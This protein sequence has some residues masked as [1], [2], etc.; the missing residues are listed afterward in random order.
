MAKKKTT[1]SNS[2]ADLFFKSAA[3]VGAKHGLEVKNF[4]DGENFTL[5]VPTGVY[6]L[7]E[8]LDYGKGLPLGVMC[9]FYG[10]ESA[11]KS[12]FAQK[13]CANAQTVY[14][15]QAI[16]YVDLECT[17]IRKRLEDIGLNLSKDR[18][19]YLD[20]NMDVVAMLDGLIDYLDGNGDKISMVVIDSIAAMY[21][22][23]NESSGPPQ[24]ELPKILGN[25]LKVL[26]GIAKKRNTTLIFINQVRDNVSLAMK[27]G[28]DAKFTPGGNAVKFFS[29]LRCEFKKV[30]GGEI[31]VDGKVIGHKV[32]LKTIK[33][34]LGIP[35]LEYEFPLYYTFVPVED[36]LFILGREKSITESGTKK[37]IG[38]RS[39]VFSYGDLKV[40]G[41]KQF[42]YALFENNRLLDLYHDLQSVSDADG[43]MES[44]VI[45]C[46][47]EGPSESNYEDMLSEEEY[48]KIEA[49]KQI[50]ETNKEYGY[51]GDIQ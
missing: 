3:E 10:K 24:F 27:M 20:Q 18:F 36:R 5:H 35:G 39:N 33:N 31:K 15:D 47:E 43:I 37:I 13:L 2:A 9:E 29:H 8:H 45:A 48:Q 16:M 50:E 30:Y 28:I 7:D 25:K 4:E 12:F 38:V 34:K 14:P 23:T 46:L 44:E 21:V 26:T 40:E 41:E 32:K 6:G 1:K 19:I 17:L 49:E 51:L 22:N 11:G 42:K